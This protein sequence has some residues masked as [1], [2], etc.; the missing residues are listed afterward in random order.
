MTMTTER[1]IAPGTAPAPRAHWSPR[2]YSCTPKDQA[3][4]RAGPP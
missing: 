3:S 1:G 2:C 4:T